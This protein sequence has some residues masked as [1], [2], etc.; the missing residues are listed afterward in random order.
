MLGQLA[1]RPAA[2]GPWVEMMKSDEYQT[3]SKTVWDSIKQT[4]S[5]SGRQEQICKLLLNGASDKQI[6]S[7][8]GIGLPTVRTHLSRLFL[9]MHVQDRCEL[10]LKLFQH[11]CYDCPRVRGSPCDP[12]E[13]DCKSHLLK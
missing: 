11:L 7:A 1:A 3:F 2:D 13:Q 6:A 5:F 12:G 9:K 4:L 10:V 8:L